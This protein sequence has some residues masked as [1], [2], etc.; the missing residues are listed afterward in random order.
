[1]KRIVLFLG[2]AFGLAWLL[3]LLIYLFQLGG[4]AAQGVM[5]VSMWAPAAAV[6]IT[7]KLT[8]NEKIVYPSMKPRFK[9]NIRWYLAAWLGPAALAL[10]GAVLYFLLFPTRFDSS[11]SYLNELVSSQTGAALPESTVL[12]VAISQIAAALTYGPAINTFFAFGEEVGW[13]GFLFPAFA[14][15]MS[16]RKAHLLTGVIWGAWHIP[17]NT[18]GHNYGTEYWGY[19]WLGAIIFCLFTFCV[20]VLLSWLTEKTNSIWPASLAHGAIN[21]AAGIPILFYNYA[22]PYVPTLGPGM[23]GLIGGIPL[24]AMGILVFILEQKTNKSEPPASQP[25]LDHN[26]DFQ[27]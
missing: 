24:F 9:G 25:E 27:L 13:R 26:K 17:I 2:F 15:R 10:V 11:L 1:M 4:F 6:W 21:A 3:W 8:A 18:M 20:G 12:V 16:K 23:Q 22:E 14:E 19:P 5:A 7:K